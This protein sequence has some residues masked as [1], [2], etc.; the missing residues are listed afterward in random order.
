MRMKFDTMCQIEEEIASDFGFYWQDN[1]LSANIK[2]WFTELTPLLR[3][4]LISHSVTAS[5]QGE[6]LKYNN[7]ICIINGQSC[8]NGLT[9]YVSVQAFLFFVKA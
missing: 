3:L 6:A 7:S 4:H 8:H 9:S 5:P 1:Q 2:L